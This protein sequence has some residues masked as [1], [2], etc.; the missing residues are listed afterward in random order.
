MHG[1]TMMKLKGMRAGQVIKGQR[2]T[3]STLL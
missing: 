3:S 2:Q 1:N